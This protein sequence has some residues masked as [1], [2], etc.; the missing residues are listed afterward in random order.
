MNMNSPLRSLSIADPERFYAVL[1]L[2]I[3]AGPN[4]ARGRNGE[5]EGDLTAIMERWQGVRAL[6]ARKI[7]H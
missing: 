6:A 1:N 3:E 5:L 2:D 7:D 4:G